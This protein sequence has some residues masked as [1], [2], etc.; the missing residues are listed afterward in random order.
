VRRPKQ[1]SIEQLKA[2][3]I[4]WNHEHPVGTRVIYHPVIG[5]KAGTETVTTHAAYVLGGHTAVTFVEGV[6]GC[7]ALDACEPLKE[8]V[9]C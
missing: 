5:E 2:E 1:K 3:C 9:A 6:S 8:P 7:V 4:V